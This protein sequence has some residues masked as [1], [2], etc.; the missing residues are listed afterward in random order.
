M[1]PPLSLELSVHQSVSLTLFIPPTPSMCTL[2]VLSGGLLSVFPSLSLELSVCQSVSQSDSLYISHSKYVYI[3]RVVVWFTVRVPSSVSRTVC[4]SVSLT[5]FISPTPSMCTLIVLSCGLLSVFPPLSLELSV[6]QSVSQS[7]SLYI[8]HPKYVY[9]DRVVVWFT[10]RVPSSV[11]RTVCLS[12]S[13]T[14]FISPTP[15][16]CTLIVLSCGLLSVFPPLS[17]ELSV[18]QSV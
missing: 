5:L 3:D 8:S 4:L 10:V 18:C 13:L 14:L 2:I 1:F 15:S 12:V 17:L 7:D 6:C 9:I 16:M 11:S